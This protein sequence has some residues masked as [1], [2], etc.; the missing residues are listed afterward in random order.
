VTFL[1]QPRSLRDDA[2]PGTFALLAACSGCLALAARPAVVWVWLSVTL[3]VGVAGAL[4]PA[5]KDRGAHPLVTL[6]VTLLAVGA[7][8]TIRFVSAVPPAP[9][10]LT[11]ALIIVSAAIAEELLFRRFLYGA[12]VRRGGAA[13]A[14]LGSAI[15]FAL[16]HIPAYG[17]GVFPLD[18]AAGLVFGWQRWST[19]SWVSPAAAHAAANLMVIL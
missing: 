16:V 5:T 6:G 8:A 15:A 11:T 1:A 10:T 14:V 18:L 9:A 19:G 3:A 7:F 4:A 12:L 13:A 17:A 2:G